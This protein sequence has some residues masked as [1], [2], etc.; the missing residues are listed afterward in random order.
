[1]KTSNIIFI[2][3]LIFLFG[4]ITLLFI[5]SKYYELE[6][7][8]ISVSQEKPL[9]PFS[10]VVAEPGANFSLKMARKIK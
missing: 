8:L 3:F 10:V 6:E 2:S 9:A 1:M 4:G 5:G 7:N